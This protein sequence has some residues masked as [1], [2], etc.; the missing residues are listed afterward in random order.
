MLSP[1]PEPRTEEEKAEH[2]QRMEQTVKKYNNWMNKIKADAYK[3]H[4]FPMSFT[5][6]AQGLKKAIV[7]RL[8]SIRGIAESSE[9]KQGDPTAQYL[10]KARSELIDKLNSGTLSREDHIDTINFLYKSNLYRIKENKY[11]LPMPAGYQEAAAAAFDKL[12]PDQQD[13]LMD[14]E[15]AKAPYK[16]P[17]D[18]SA[19]PDLPREYPE[20]EFELKER[21]R[22]KYY[23]PGSYFGQHGNIVQK[24]EGEEEV[25]KDL[26]EQ[27]DQLDSILGELREIREEEGSATMSY[28]FLASNPEY[29]EEI[30][31][32]FDLAKTISESLYAVPIVKKPKEGETTGLLDLRMDATKR[33]VVQQMADFM[34]RWLAFK[35]KFEGPTPYEEGEYEPMPIPAPATASS[36]GWKRIFAKKK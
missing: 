8:E 17:T 33:H 28:N 36:K 2:R 31:D 20:S 13:K 35:N 34:W 24:E 10:S 3:P 14:V 7:E 9:A 27:I 19:I 21:R 6:A 26:Y 11:D 1:E 16:F 22:N 5:G 12:S 4:M 25:L 30:N 29:V 18:V 23:S 15:K 32:V